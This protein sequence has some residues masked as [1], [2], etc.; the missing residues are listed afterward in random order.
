[1]G[2][3]I[4]LQPFWPSTSVRYFRLLYLAILCSENSVLCNLHIKAYFDQQENSW[5]VLFCIICWTQICRLCLKTQFSTIFNKSVLESA[6]QIKKIDLDY[7]L[8]NH[9]WFRVACIILCNLQNINSKILS[10][11]T[12]PGNPISD[13]WQKKKKKKKIQN[14]FVS[15]Y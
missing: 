13:Y 14:I 2:A 10:T 9:Q 6:Q 8:I 15:I 1:M 7:Y 12:H 11:K 5:L 4:W 3:I